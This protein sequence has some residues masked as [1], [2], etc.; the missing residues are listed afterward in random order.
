MN[1]EQSFFFIFNSSYINKYNFLYVIY[2]NFKK[3][4]KTGIKLDNYC[5]KWGILRI[6]QQSFSKRG[7]KT[8]KSCRLM[9]EYFSFISVMKNG[10]INRKKFL[11]EAA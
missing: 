4:D 11:Q 7:R 9:E 6:P 1:K 5:W 8:I 2:F 10:M 3:Q